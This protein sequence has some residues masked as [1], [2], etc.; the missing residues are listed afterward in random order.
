MRTAGRSVKITINRKPEPK[1]GARD[2]LIGKG[3]MWEWRK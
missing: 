1:W 2:Y 3:Y